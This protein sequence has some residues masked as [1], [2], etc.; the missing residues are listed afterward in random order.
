MAVPPVALRDGLASGYV[1]RSEQRRHAVTLVIMGLARRYARAQWQNRLCA[2]E[3]LDLTFLIHAE[4]DGVV[5]R[6]HVQPD[7]I[8]HLLHELWI[9]GDLKV[10]HP[11]WLQTE[12]VPDAHH[13]RLR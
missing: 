9:F 1:Q 12:C 13:C 3:C 5:W 7:D 6:T 4:H 2:V 11:M 10:L 8:P